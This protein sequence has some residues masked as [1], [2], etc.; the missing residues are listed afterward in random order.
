MSTHSIQAACAA[1]ALSLS[2]LPALAADAVPAPRII[3]TGEGE[4]TVLPDMAV[5][6]L[7]VQRD[8]ATARAALDANN[9]AMAAVIAA[10]KSETIAER[11]LQTSNFSINPLY[12]YPKPDAPDQTPK[13][14][15]YQVV[16]TL[17]VRLRDISKIGAVLDKSVTLGV[18]QGGG[19]SFTNDDPAAT[20]TEA[21][22][23]AVQD[24]MAKAKVLADAAGVGLGKV[25]E[26]SEQSMQPQPMPFAMK[27][28]A[29]AADS[30]PVQAGE[31]SY[32]VQ[33]NVTFEIAQ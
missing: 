25:V 10:M 3:V 1:F 17:S 28:R 19:I 12:V 29:E 24:A 22:K 11:D 8:A 16:N 2:A 13:I 6:T 26:I 15:G 7:S 5:L 21:R 14:T 27:A 9:D 18:N 20:V 32:R 4:A 33:V 23:R 31:N 30:V